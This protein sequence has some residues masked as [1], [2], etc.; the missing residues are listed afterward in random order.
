MVQPST[1]Q[2]NFKVATYTNVRQQTRA[3]KII[4]TKMFSAVTVIFS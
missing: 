3:E 4:K 1:R 2:R